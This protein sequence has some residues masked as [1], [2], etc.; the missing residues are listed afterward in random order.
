MIIIKKSESGNNWIEYAVAV[1][2]VGKCLVAVIT[3]TTF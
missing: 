3:A 1:I 2:T